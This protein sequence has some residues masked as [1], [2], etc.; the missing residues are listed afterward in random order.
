MAY[1]GKWTAT[2]QIPQRAVD[3][4]LIDRF[5]SLNDSDGGES[6]RYNLSLDYRAP[7]AGGT[8]QTTAYGNKYYLNLFSDFTGQVSANGEHFK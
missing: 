2:D 4:G 1:N 7:L 3:E 8:L 5:G 6:Y